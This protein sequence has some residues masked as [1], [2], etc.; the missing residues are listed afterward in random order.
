MSPLLRRQLQLWL[1]EATSPNPN[2]TVKCNGL[3]VFVKR[4]SASAEERETYD[5]LITLLDKDF[6]NTE[7][8]FGGVA[9]Y[10]RMCSQENQHLH[11]A[12]LNWVRKQL[13]YD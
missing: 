11:P 7:Y 8:P 10:D 2:V 9:V 4:I 13:G 12:R 6:G 5:E 1:R 3:C